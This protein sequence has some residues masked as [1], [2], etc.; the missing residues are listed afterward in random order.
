MLYI[1]FFILTLHHIKIIIKELSYIKDPSQN[2]NKNTIR[3]TRKEKK[4]KKKKGEIDKRERRERGW[5]P[6]VVASS[7]CRRGK[8]PQKAFNLS[9]TTVGNTDLNQKKK[10]AFLQVWEKREKK[11][12]REKRIP[13]ST[14]KREERR[15]KRKKK[16]WLGEYVHVREERGKKKKEG[17]E[18][19]ENKK[20]LFDFTTC[21][22]TVACCKKNLIFGVWCAKC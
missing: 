4:K 18:R 10:K 7:V 20:L 17:A 12:K 15:E 5:W 22:S 6:L 14:Q 13:I 21:Y 3:Q 16:R 8:S 9:P 1:T 11:Y 19:R 2:K